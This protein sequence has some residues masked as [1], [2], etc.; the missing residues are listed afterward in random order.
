MDDLVQWLGAQLDEDERIARDPVC[1]N[2]G[3]RIVPLESPFGVTGYTHEGGWE[4]RRCP[5]S[6][7]GAERVQNPARVLREIEAK[8]RLL[9]AYVQV[10]AYDVN[11]VEYAHGYANALGEAVHLLALPFADRPGY[12]ES[13]RP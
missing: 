13:W 7:V 2:C 1:V 4:G 5:G 12:R 3:N 10:A 8:R 6:L 11:E 9:A